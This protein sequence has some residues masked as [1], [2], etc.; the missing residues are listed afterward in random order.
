MKTVTMWSYESGSR[1]INLHDVEPELF[2][3]LR[4]AF[5]F[6]E[7]MPDWIGQINVDKNTTIIFFKKH[8]DG[9]E[10][11]NEKTVENAKAEQPVC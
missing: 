11:N 10:A 6:K 2:E 1:E 9:K 8:D 4:P 5:A 7:G 3:K